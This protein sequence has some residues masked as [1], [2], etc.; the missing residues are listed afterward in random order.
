M[1]KFC[2]RRLNVGVCM[3]KLNGMNRIKLTA[4]SLSTLEPIIAPRRINQWVIR[5][6]RD[7][8]PVMWLCRHS[9]SSLAM[10]FL[11]K[12]PARSPDLSAA[13]VSLRGYLEA[14]AQ[15]KQT[16]FFF[17]F[18]TKRIYLIS[19]NCPCMYATRF[20]LYL[21]HFQACQHKHI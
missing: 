9:D 7:R 13:D 3:H 11:I 4:Q 5:M 15:F 1:H 21:G 16:A 2:V 14:K 6:N 17:H 10:K 20:G 12:W 18:N 19:L 8:D